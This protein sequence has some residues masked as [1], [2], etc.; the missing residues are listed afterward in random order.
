M[1]FL[2]DKVLQDTLDLISAA[3]MQKN[4]SLLKPS[5]NTKP[6]HGEFWPH[7]SIT[8]YVRTQD[9]RPI[10]EPSPMGRRAEFQKKPNILRAP[11]IILGLSGGPDSVFLLHVLQQLQKNNVLTLVA[12]HLDHQWRQESWQDVEFCKQLCESLNVAFIS[13]KASEL[14][15]SIKP[16]G[17]AEEIGRKMRR[18][19][20]AQ[21]LKEK[22]ADFIALAHHLQ[23][24]QETFFLRLL[25]GASLTGLS[26]M[27][28]FD[29]LYIRPLLGVDK[30]DILEYLNSNKIKHL[31]DPTNISQ[32]YLRNRIRLNVI[33]A[34]K[35]CDSRFDQKFQS[36]IEQLRAEDDFLK[37]LAEH[38]FNTVFV[39]QNADKYY[40]GSL[41]KIRTLHPIVAKRVILH[42]LI[43]EK[44]SFSLS[45][46]Y[47]HEILKFLR[48]E[49]G[50]KHKVGHN[51]CIVKK[52]DHFWLES[53]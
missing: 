6:A 17:S 35:Q 21:V 19:L 36:T 5:K 7:P 32:D 23:D 43:Q 18:F 51:W 52:Q 37:L 33:P 29:G 39:K 22:Q 47:L 26:C 45:S 49:R 41:K 16:N 2:I 11:K 15:L 13:R 34:I 31:V 4:R 30:Q 27:R 53:I 44:V 48:S 20:F 9:E 46:K 40:Q 38:E 25:R 3:C 42:W 24:Q 14:N 12:V 50:G 10:I 28:V 1:N 8:H